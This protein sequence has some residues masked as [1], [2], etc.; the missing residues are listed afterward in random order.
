MKSTA[1]LPPPAADQAPGP[2]NDQG[3]GTGPGDTRP[4]LCIPYWETPRLPSNSVD[5][6][7]LRPLPSGLGAP[8]DDPEGPQTMAEPGF[9]WLQPIA[10]SRLT[11]RDRKSVV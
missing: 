5:I 2:G 1:S 3:H 8:S 6:G 10:D 11:D 9:G 7:Q 4:Y